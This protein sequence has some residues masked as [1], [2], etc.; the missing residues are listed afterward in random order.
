MLYFVNVVKDDD[1]AS[2][3][4]WLNQE[5]VD[6]VQVVQV[7]EA[8]SAEE[9]DPVDCF[10]W[11]DGHWVGSDAEQ[12]MGEYYLQP[13]PLWKFVN[14]VNP[15]GRFDYLGEN[16]RTV[17]PVFS[18]LGHILLKCCVLAWGLEWQV[19][20]GSDS[21]LSIG[22]VHEMRWFSDASLAG[23]AHKIFYHA[24]QGRAVVVGKH[25]RHFWLAVDHDEATDELPSLA[26]DAQP[27][28]LARIP[29]D[30]RRDGHSD[31]PAA[32]HVGVRY[33]EARA[34]V[35]LSLLVAPLQARAVVFGVFY[36]RYHFL[37]CVL[38]CLHCLRK[39]EC[40]M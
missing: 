10:N 11:A 28:I 12:Q 40:L 32:D 36:F 4:K 33:V 20:G 39:L 35:W 38:C 16:A 34:I 3:P 6:E 7:S 24:V 17:T 26:D 18:L 5:R 27:T 22:Q 1:G 14:I 15:L 37:V 29:A 23:V 30:E 9:H 8:E 13:K 31:Q 21:W 2:A 19:Q 25:L